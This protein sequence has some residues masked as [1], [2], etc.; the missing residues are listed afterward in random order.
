GFATADLKINMNYRNGA[1]MF[2]YDNIR[3][4]GKTATKTFFN[5]MDWNKGADNIALTANGNIFTFKATISGQVDTNTFVDSFKAM[6]ITANVGN[7]SFDTGWTADG[8]MGYRVKK[9][10]DAEFAEGKVFETYKLG[11]TLGGLSYCSENQVQIGYYTT[12]WVATDNG[13]YARAGYKFGLGESVSL[14]VKVAALSNYKWDDSDATTDGSGYLGW[15]VFLEPEFKGILGAEVF[16]K[17]RRQ[18]ENNYG[19]VFGGYAK[20]LCLPVLNDSALGGAVGLWGG[21]VNEWSAD[22]R[23]RF[24]LSDSI[25]LTTMNNFTMMM[26][27][28]GKKVSG[29]A[30]KDLGTTSGLAGFDGFDSSAL[31]WNVLALR[32]KLNDTLTII[33]TVGQQTDFDSGD[34]KDGTQLFVYPHVQ[35]YAASNASIVAGVV[36]ALNEIGAKKTTGHEKFDIRVSVPV[37]FRV[38]M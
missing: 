13:Y 17:G 24:V 32:F 38:T 3:E 10:V 2:K 7:F 6:Q 31:L 14:G 20:L 19:F 9:D 27:N 11:S 33:G 8:V 30:K 28:Q 29:D 35:I 18:D 23:L 4:K 26:R 12:K 34:Y 15:S 5:L 21:H 37:T 36:A 1:D 16:A 25:S 22:L